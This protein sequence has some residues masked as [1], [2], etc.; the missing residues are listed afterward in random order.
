M[1]YTTGQKILASDINT[2]LTTVRNV[3]GAGSG[4][5]G[6][7]QSAIDQANAK[8][9]TDVNPTVVSAEQWANLRAMLMTCANHQGTSVSS[10]AAAH[11]QGT[12]VRPLAGLAAAAPLIDANRLTA[13]PGSMTLTAGAFTLT[14]SSSWTGTLTANFVVSFGNESAAR[15]FFNSGGQI[16]IRLSQPTGTTEDTLIH[17]ALIEQVG[18]ISIGAYATT[19]SGSHN[20]DANAAGYYSA[21]DDPMSLVYTHFSGST[22]YASSDANANTLLVKITRLNHSTGNTGNGNA[23]RITVVLTGDGAVSGGTTLTCDHYRATTYLTGITIPQFTS[24]GGWLATGH[25]GT[26]TMFPA[27]LPSMKA[28]Q[29]FATSFSASG[30]TGPYSYFKSAGAFPTGLTLTGDTLSGTPTTAGA[31]NFSI[32][33]IDD[34]G[35][36][37]TRTY[38]GTIAA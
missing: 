13:A 1:T 33:G 17:N 14:R 26:I 21:G 24:S 6:Y 7:G 3:Y 10:L 38:T 27:G 20:Q 30:G 23:I 34:L 18:T 8:P 36:S 15:Y 2:F 22:G 19:L 11:A 12:K 32:I 9:S 5:R 4:D 29:S 31:Y 37:A 16:R 28:N 35:N 25:S